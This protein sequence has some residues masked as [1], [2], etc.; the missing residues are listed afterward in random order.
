MS[1]IAKKTGGDFTPA[2]AGNHVAVCYAV[3]D[4]GHQHNEA[5]TLNDGSHVPES[6]K[7]QV[8]L[9]WELP[10]EMVTYKDESGVE[11][12]KPAVI[13]KFY[14]NSLHEKAALT[15]HLEA[16]RGRQFTVKETQGFDIANILGKPCML[17]VVH[18]EAGKAKI[19]G[20]ASMIKGV[21]APALTNELMMFNLDEFTE[22]Q[23]NKIPEGIQ[24]IIKKS[25]E[26]EKMH[27]TAQGFR[28]AGPD[29]G[30]PGGGN[31]NDDD[32]PF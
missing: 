32:I 24:N 15:Q 18:T 12:T 9:M 30:D 3:I 14:T 10:N 8:L 31:F 11:Q 26:W 19:T 28:D 4:L 27:P 16:W 7:P 29:V 25:K 2:P 5:F 23:F 1:L 20:V 17:N 21:D 6:I 13:S 22:E